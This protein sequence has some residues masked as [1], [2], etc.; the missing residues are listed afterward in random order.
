M[1][2]LSHARRDPSKK[3]TRCLLSASSRAALLCVSSLLLIFL[4]NQWII[5]LGV[6]LREDLGSPWQGFQEF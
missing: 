4:K 6:W 5:I 1:T 3:R 2:L